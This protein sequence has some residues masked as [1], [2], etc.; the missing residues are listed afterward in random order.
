MSQG[1]FTVYL[2]VLLI[3]VAIPLFLFALRRPSPNVKSERDVLLNKARQSVGFFKP[4]C[5]RCKN[6][7][8]EAGQ[9][10]IGKNPMFA[11]AARLLSPTQMSGREPAVG[12]EQAASPTVSRSSAEESDVDEEPTRVVDT[13]KQKQ[14]PIALDSWQL[15]GV[16][17]AKNELRHAID[18]C[19]SFRRKWL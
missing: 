19:P 2:V 10:E 8:L 5:S 17:G 11:T 6:W 14:L 13:K 12:M 7:D 18:G 15:F 4:S 1:H 9:V 3:A 16:C